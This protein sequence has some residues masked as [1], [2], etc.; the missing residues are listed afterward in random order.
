MISLYGRMCKALGDPPKARVASRNQ[1]C[2]RPFGTRASTIGPGGPFVGNGTEHVFQTHTQAVRGAVVAPKSRK[3]C[4]AP[5]DH[6][7]YTRPAWGPPL[8]FGTPLRAH[9]PFQDPVAHTCPPPS[10]HMARSRTLLHTHGF[11]GGLPCAA[12]VCPTTAAAQ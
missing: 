4:R 5:P 7:A 2:P 9:G 11:S 10:T 1:A 6:V 12:V 3:R 8:G